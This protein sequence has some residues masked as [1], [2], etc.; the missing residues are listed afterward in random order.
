MQEMEEQS[1]EEQE[2]TMNKQMDS[3]EQQ[4]EQDEI[5]NLAVGQV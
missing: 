4:N 1:G 3:Q 2:D 5:L